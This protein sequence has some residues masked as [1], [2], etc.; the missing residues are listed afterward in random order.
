[1]FN[2]SNIKTLQMR[3]LMHLQ[4]SSATSNLIIKLINLFPKY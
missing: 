2:K 4:M 3:G 1:M